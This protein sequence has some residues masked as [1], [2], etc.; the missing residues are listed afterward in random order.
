M[1]SEKLYEGIGYMDDKWM[2]LLD[3]PI[4]AKTKKNRRFVGYE[5]K[6][7][8][9]VKY[10]WVFLFVMLMLNSAVAWYTADKTLAASEPV[11]MISGFFEEYFEAPEELNAYYKKMQD[12]N[13]EQQ[14]LLRE[15]MRN[16]NMDFEPETL[17]DLY[18]T[19]E[20]YPDKMLFS[21]LYTA[22]SAA[23]KY[24]EQLEKVIERAKAN[25]DAFSDMGIYED[26]FTYKYQLKVIELYEKMQSSVELE[27]E[28]TRG[29]NEYFAY[30]TVN[31]FIF[32]MLIMLGSLIFVQ[33]KQSGFIPIMRTAKNGRART[34]VA[35]L[36]TVMLLTVCFVLLFT[37]STFA[38]YGLRLGFSSTENVIQALDS[39]T[40]SPY[41][42][43]VGEYFL[44]TLGVKLLTFVLFSMAV[45]ALSA[46]FYNYILIYIIGLG[47]FGVNFL[48][49]TLS[50][51]DANS[52]FK[53]LNLVA[54][55]SV[56]SLFTRYRAMGV[57]G[58]VVGFVS[59]MLIGFSILTIVCA[60]AAV[61]IYVRGADSVRAVRIEL[62]DRLAAFCMTELA[63]LKNRLSH[64][65]A[66]KKSRTR[67]YSNS[68]ILA[69]CFKTLISSKFI[70]IVLLIL[71]VK[72]WYSYNVNQP[73]NSYSDSVYKEYMTR[74]EGELTDEKLD[75][76]AAEREMIDA[77]LS[78]EREMQTAYINN[79]ISF[80]EYREY[81]SDYNYAYSRSRLLETI[82]RHAEYLV[83]KEA[84]TDVRGWF[85]YDT[86]W[87]KMYS[88]DADLFL[89]AAILLLLTG[90]FAAEYVSKSSSGCFAQ[91]L[92]STKNGRHKTFYA[93]LI[94]SGM[95]SVILA[96]LTG[97]VDVVVIINGYDLPAMNAPLVSMQM[98]A[99]VSGDITIAQY[100][101]VFCVMRIFGALLMAMLVCALSELLARYI[102]ILGTAVILT[103]LPALCAYFG[104][105]AAEKVNFL[106][107]LAGTPLF[108]QSANM[109]MLG[110]GYTMLILWLTTAAIAVTAMLL[111]AKRMFVK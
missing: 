1:K 22:I 25:L 103:L 11:Q 60:V 58:N 3:E 26:S 45:T 57:F 63:R 41:R 82:E 56:N 4:V 59:A 48:L 62:L 38:V 21:K 100:F 35:K 17:P 102:P 93:K 47:L 39:F 95:I 101:M 61:M 108:L 67:S 6:K 69:E 99:D 5:L 23:E 87:Q 36:I 2:K 19:D 111:S 65:S 91:L 51:I 44:I 76:I 84:E 54:T 16:G 13:A 10:L 49:Y 96:I 55:S 66:R 73:S 92:R 72:V 15:A 89:Y 83:Q 20:S 106:N 52:V 28:Y 97:L 90:S 94:S 14:S 74:L 8:F 27:V 75:Y 43:T 79:E 64:I 53:N 7:L 24:P 107:L 18:S 33:E 46:I 104:L 78:K 81:L 77:T 88:E 71:G 31:I 86:G 85:I 42:I 50:Y 12:F 80:D 30:D 9:G 105:A 37:L 29:W 40:F 68:L 110:N 32:A 70:I 109:S 34:A 98:F